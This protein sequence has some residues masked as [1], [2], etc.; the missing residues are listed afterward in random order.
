MTETEIDRIIDALDREHSGDAW[1]GSPLTQILADIDHEQASARPFQG[2]HTIWELVLHVTAWKNEVRRRVD[3]GAA[4]LPAEGDWPTPA[5]P[6][7]ETWREALDALD[8]SHGTLVAAITR[9]PDSRILAP[10]NDQRDRETGHGVSYY[11]MLHGIVQHD[12]YHSGQIALLRKAI[13]GE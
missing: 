8:D 4:G 2:V 13:Q 9:L 12:V 10:T 3:G 7:Q 11:V 5:A 1:H 6:G